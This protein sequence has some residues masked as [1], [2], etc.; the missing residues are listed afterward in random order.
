MPGED[1]KQHTT[2]L[3]ISCIPFT[4]EGGMAVMRF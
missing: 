4:W 3:R 2:I 1:V